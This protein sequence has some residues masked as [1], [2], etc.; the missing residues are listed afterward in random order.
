MC[1]R[2]RGKGVPAKTTG[3]RLHCFEAHPCRPAPT[4]ARIQCASLADVEARSWVHAKCD[5]PPATARN[6]PAHPAAG[7]SRA[8]GWNAV[9][10]RTNPRERG[11]RSC[12]SC[13]QVAGNP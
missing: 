11:C 4:R 6:R 1:I 7:S 5:Q 3:W 2:D 10:P 13:P 12:G 9:S 8:D